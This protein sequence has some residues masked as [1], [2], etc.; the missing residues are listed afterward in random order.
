I[1]QGHWPVEL[2]RLREN[3]RKAP[4]WQIQKLR[5]S[6]RHF[7]YCQPLLIDQSG[8]VMCG[9]ARLQALLAEG[10]ATAPVIVAPSSWS[11]RD[12]AAFIRFDNDF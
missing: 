5:A 10:Y 7:S 6:F 11:A 9:S 2:L 4:A 8:L 3:A 1:K 12:I